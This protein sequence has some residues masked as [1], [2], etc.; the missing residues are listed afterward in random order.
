MRRL[1]ET[2]CTCGS[3]HATFGACLRS[4]N[5]RVGY[6]RSAAG[7]GDYTEQKKW[8]SEL[9]AY[10]S[11]RA[12]GIQPDG[13]RTQQIQKAVEISDKTGRAYGDTS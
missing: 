10:R 13:T 11:A 6:C 4:K 2:R 12:Q 5:I 7:G 9:A 1:S 8:D 3:G